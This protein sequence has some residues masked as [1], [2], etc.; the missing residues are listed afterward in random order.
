M[1]VQLNIKSAEAR[2]LAE[3]LA[4]ATGTSIIAAVTDALRHHRDDLDAARTNSDAEGRAR[5]DRIMA[6]TEGNRAHW[7]KDMLT[8]DHGDLLYDE[9]GLP[10]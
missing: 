7:V 1:G 5:Y 6:M 4:A 3:E 2:A 9:R 8:I 10:Q